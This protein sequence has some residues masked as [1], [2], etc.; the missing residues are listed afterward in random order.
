MR[1]K[2]TLAN[3]R[4]TAITLDGPRGPAHCAQPGAI[5][6]A[7]VSGQ[8]IVPVH[9]EAAAYWTAGSWDRTQVPKPFSQMAM[10]IGTPLE[11]PAELTDGLLEAKRQELEG[12]LNQLYKQACQMLGA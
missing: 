8:P 9:I 2:R 6:L 1:L 5:W 12:A 4:A 3:G 10:A 7:S 11:V